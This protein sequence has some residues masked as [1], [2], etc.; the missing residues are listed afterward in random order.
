MSVILTFIGARFGPRAI[1]AAS[2][3]QISFRGYNHRAKINPYMSWA[4][5]LDCGDIPITPF[6]NTLALKQMSEAY[7]DLGTR[8]PIAK[9]ITK[10]KLITLGGDHSIALPA[11]R[12]LHAIHGEQLAVVHFDAHLD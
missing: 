9:S 12:A 1:R 2:S 11:L 3:R 7:R 4:N 8:K 6:D 5:I 10:P